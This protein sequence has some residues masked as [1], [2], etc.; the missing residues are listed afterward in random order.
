MGNIVRLTCGYT[1]TLWHVKV[2]PLAAQCTD[3][4]VSKHRYSQTGQRYEGKASSSAYRIAALYARAA[5][6]GIGKGH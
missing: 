5:I 2:P 4:A 6:I 3:G 1:I